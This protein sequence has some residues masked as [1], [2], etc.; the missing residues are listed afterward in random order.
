MSIIKKAI[1]TG[2]AGFIGHH[3]VDRLLDEGWEVWNFD[4][5]STGRRD[6]LY[7]FSVNK[8]YHPVFID[9]H[10]LSLQQLDADVVFN[11]AAEP[12][13]QRVQQ[14]PQSTLAANVSLV[15]HLAKQCKAFKKP[16][17]HCSSS[18]VYGYSHNKGE[19]REELVISPTNTYGFQKALAES[20]IQDV[21]SNAV[22]LRFFNVYGE[23][24]PNGSPYTGVITKFLKQHREGKPITIYGDGTQERDF[25]SAR[26]VVDAIIKSYE[27]ITKN[28]GVH[29]FNIGSA[30]PVSVYQIA[31][32]IGGD[33]EYMEARQGDVQKT[34]ANIEKARKD[35]GWEPK[36][37]V[38]GW[39][40][41]QL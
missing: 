30:H 32:A 33:I 20:I 29:T 35:L 41:S 25:T 2:G 15:V 27:Y 31:R 10:R 18:S 13:M 36:G 23:G 7:R 1:C 14:N 9:G 26:D 17:I 16:L 40:K 28:A 34:R 39:V 8:N 5:L 3:L 22:M 4:N 24:Q 6:N 11:C 37:N 38:L 19:V 12:R 21:Q